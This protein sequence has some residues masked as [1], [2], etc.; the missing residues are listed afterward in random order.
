M[1]R[2]L[3]ILGC[4]LFPMA[5]Q[6]TSLM[7]SDPKPVGQP[8][9][10]VPMMGAEEPPMSPRQMQ[11]ALINGFTGAYASTSGGNTPPTVH[12]TVQL[13]VRFCY[14]GDM[15]FSEGAIFEGKVCG[16]DSP[17]SVPTWR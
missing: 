3:I 5:V 9:S 16:R 8:R 2:S 14:A 1:K 12:H 13:D 17:G 7:D 10:A 4:L 15:A 6:A 11:Q